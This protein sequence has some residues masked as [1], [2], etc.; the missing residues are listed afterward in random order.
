MIISKADCVVDASIAIK[1]FIEQEDSDLAESLLLR[2]SGNPPARFA[3]PDLFYVE[4]ANVFW[5]YVQQT[6][7]PVVQAQLSLQRLKALNLQVYPLSELLEE[8]LEVAIAYRISVYDACYV[9]LSLY[10]QCPLI[11]ADRKLLRSLV[12]SPYSLLL[13][14]DFLDG[15]GNR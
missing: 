9:V 3:V 12:D 8:A 6:G 11:T 14:S 2:L 15:E 5:K 1:L 10:A 13:L 4:C 7:F